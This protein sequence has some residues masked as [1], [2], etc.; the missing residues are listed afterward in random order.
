[1]IM[2]ATATNMPLVLLCPMMGTRLTR[3]AAQY[4]EKGFTQPNAAS[5]SMAEY[6]H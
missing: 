4:L 5:L 6:S 1:M 3:N 2:M